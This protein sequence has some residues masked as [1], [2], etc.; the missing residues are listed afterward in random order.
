MMT[1][2]ASPY[3]FGEHFAS[4]AMEHLEAAAVRKKSVATGSKQGFQKSHPQ[5][6]TILNPGAAGVATSVAKRAAEAK[7]QSMQWKPVHK[8]MLSI[9]T[10]RC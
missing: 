5:A 10:F 4:V 9:H 2:D 3:L 8:F 6:R 7:G 1:K